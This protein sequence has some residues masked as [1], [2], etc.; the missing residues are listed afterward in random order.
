MQPPTT[1]DLAD[2]L[3][4]AT[5]YQV[6]HSLRGLLP[7]PAADSPEGVPHHD[8]AAIELVAALQPATPEQANLATQYVA[9][10]LQALHCLHLA[11]AQPQ[12][13]ARVLQCTAQSASM[14]RQARFWRAALERTQ[15][16]RRRLSAEPAVSDADAAPADAAPAEPPL[17]DPTAQAERYALQH[18]KRAMLIRRLGR[19]PDRIDIGRLPPR[20]VHA[21]VS[22]ST[23]ILRALD[24]K[25]PRAMVLAA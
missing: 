3:P 5:Y 10:S 6:V 1:P 7:P 14:M 13:A 2:T 4:K 18:R 16:E 8:R 22:G 15:A 24:E 9:A 21:L 11:H 12:D 25:R 23:P 20:V 17:A 19:L